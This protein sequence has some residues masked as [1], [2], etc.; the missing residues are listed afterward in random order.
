MS[1]CPASEAP[2][3]HLEA[4]TGTEDS[5]EKAAGDEGQLR[6]CRGQRDSQEEGQGVLAEFR[7][8]RI[9]T[10]WQLHYGTRGK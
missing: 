10:K 8:C 6:E 7:T 1:K 5:E 9:L 2:M 4:A 3:F